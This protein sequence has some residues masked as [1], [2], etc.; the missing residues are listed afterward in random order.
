MTKF[1]RQRESIRQ[2]LAGRYDHPTADMIYHDVQQQ[3]PNISLGTVYR[4]LS[5]MADQGEI[6]RLSCGS[7]P[8]RFDG[9]THPHYHFVCRDCGGV[10]DLN[11]PPMDHINVLAGS[12]FAGQIEGH[13]AYFYGICPECLGG[14]N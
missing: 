10:S 3:F 13:Q 2:C 14:K 4:N 1:S 7:G 9:R 8:E 12:G 5:M 6:L 11:L